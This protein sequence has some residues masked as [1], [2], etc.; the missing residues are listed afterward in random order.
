MLNIPFNHYDKILIPLKYFKFRRVKVCIKGKFIESLQ[1]ALATSLSLVKADADI[2]IT[3][4][5]L[6]RVCPQTLA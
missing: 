6:R 3:E 1:S 5:S 2:S 4:S